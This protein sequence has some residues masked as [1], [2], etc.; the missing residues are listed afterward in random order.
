MENPTTNA[1]DYLRGNEAM[2]LAK[3][4]IQNNLEA[5]P[6]IS[7]IS[8]ITF[9][10]ESSLKRNFKAAYGYSIYQFIQYSRVMKAKTLLETGKYNIKQV[11]YKVGYSNASHFSSA[12]KKHISV[13]PSVYINQVK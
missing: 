7:D 1:N 10:S 13:L 11:A 3:Q 8:K 9:Q 4:Y 6:S 2:R 12:F 5:P